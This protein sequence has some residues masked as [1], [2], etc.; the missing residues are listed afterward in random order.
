MPTTG[1]VA[2]VYPIG[3]LPADR[4]ATP[5]AS[6]SG[7][8]TMD[9]VRGSLWRINSNGL[10]QPIRH[11]PT[12]PLKPRETAQ[13]ADAQVLADGSRVIFNSR[14]NLRAEVVF[15][16]D[17][18]RPRAIEKHAAV[19]VDP[20]GATQLADAHAKGQ[21]AE[22]GKT[23]KPPK[24][25]K[26]PTQTINDKI[27]CTIAKQV[28]RVPTLVAGDRAARSITLSWIYQRLDPSDC[29]PST[30]VVDI[31]ALTSGAP[32][33]P[34]GQVRVQGDTAVTLT[35]LFPDTE[36]Q[37]TVTAYINLQ[38]TSSAPIDVTTGPEGPAAPT[39]VRATA[40]TAGNWTVSWNSCG[41]I[42]QG[43][44]PSNTWYVIPN[45]C[46]GRG[47]SA[48][49]A[50]ITVSGDPTQ[51]SF[52][53]VFAGGTA[54]LGRALCF[55]VQGVGPQGTIGTTSDPSAPAY[56]WSNPLARTMQ[57]HA[58]QPAN[59]DF[60]ATTTTTVDLD[61]GADPI[62]D[63]GGVGASIDLQLTGPGGTETKTV[64]WDGRSD[65]VSAQFAGIKAGAQYS[66]RASVA[67]PRHP[68][69]AVTVGPVTV[70]TRAN[71]PQVTAQASCPTG[72]GP[73]TL[74]C[75]LVVQLSGP[76]SA[77]AGGERFDLTGNSNLVCGGG[78]SAKPL[79]K[80]GFDPS[81]E[82]ITTSVDLLT[83]NGQCTVNVQLAEAGRAGGPL[84]FGGT[85]SPVIS[86]PVDL[87][88]ASTLGASG[89]DFGASFD[90]NNPTAT[91]H[92]NGNHDAV[93]Q[94]TLN[95]HEQVHAPDGTLCGGDNTGQSGPPD[96]TVD[97]RPLDQ[98]V[99]TQGDQS[100]WTFD[101]SYQ[102]IRDGTTHSFTGIAIAGKPS[103]FIPPCDVR[104]AF[105]AQW[106]GDYTAPSVTVTFDN[107]GADLRGCSGFSYTVY[108]P[109]KVKR[110]VSADEGDTP[111][112]SESLGTLACQDD[113][114]LPGRWLVEITYS[115]ARHDANPIDV[116][117]AGDPPQPP[118]PPPSSSPPPSEPPPPT[119][120][121]T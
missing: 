71:W 22:H 42:A 27:D 29:V 79:S 35:H 91:I 94:L 13:F 69:N 38:H 104:G 56:S 9:T 108:E 61:L 33:P 112:G 52:T 40:D 18:H 4:L 65:R 114:T 97:L 72:G 70:T 88:Q 16:D 36:Y 17:S 75:T 43:C 31:K 62:R 113:F 98:C 30:Y 3:A 45:F 84:V 116:D 73:V 118:P 19:Q 107:S 48:A 111:P 64:V 76:S 95:W 26:Q 2:R 32:S 55:Q 85:T 86:T 53:H 81:S 78:N 120:T 7:I 44:V 100:G 39:D 80:D 68:A 105:S 101:V 99:V 119:P 87:G 34:R 109:L 1:T 28:P 110:C 21:K 83:Y 12:Y 8:Y 59:T 82:Q 58:S 37:L 41:G 5:A 14:A 90:P 92:Y 67:P 54:L 49:P 77:Q 50:R 121:P 23:R 89:S 115:S 47:L 15:S 74:S 6:N 63:V 93:S 51:H 57:L 46:D 103:G 117:V 10:A 24:T 25:A 102:D 96:V 106:T 20:S 66:A 11:A 60:G